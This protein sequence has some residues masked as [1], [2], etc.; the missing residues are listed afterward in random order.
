MS[1]GATTRRELLRC[2]QAFAVASALALLHVRPAFAQKVSKRDARYQV[3]MDHHQGR[4]CA[5]CLYFKP[6]RGG[7]CSGMMNATCAVVEGRVSPM[8]YCDLFMTRDDPGP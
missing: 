1:D 5:T 7:T 4:R 2:L 3:F 6:G 8:G